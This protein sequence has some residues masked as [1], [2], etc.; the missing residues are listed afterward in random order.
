VP[1]LDTQSFLQLA[2]YPALLLSECQ[3][4]AK[5]L[6]FNAAAAQLFQDLHRHG[7]CPSLLSELFSLDQLA[8]PRT[9]SAQERPLRRCFDIDLT[10][11][12]EGVL[13]LLRDVTESWVQSRLLN[14]LGALQS[15]FL[16]GGL[17]REAFSD[18]LSL[19]LEVT[20]SEYG[21]VGEVLRD[22]N[23][24]PY[25]RTFAI[26]DVTWDDATRQFFDRHHKNGLEFRN[27]NTLFGY[28]LINGQSLIANSPADHPASVGTPQG[29]PPLNS[30]LALPL[31]LG[32]EMVGL[33]GIANRP[34]GYENSILDWLEP[35]SRVSAGAIRGFQTLQA[36]RNLE[37]ERDAYLNSSSAIH[38]VFDL[39]GRFHRVNPALCQLL[40]L[41]PE[42]IYRSDFVAFVHPDDIEA[43]RSEFAA[44]V[45]GRAANGFEN[46]F[47]A[48]DGSYRWLRWMTPPPS[49]D[50]KFI[51]ATAMDITEHKRM[52]DEVHRL[53]LV[54]QRTNN[55]IIL[56][57]ASGAIE[58][59][60][61]GF[62]RLSGYTLDEVRGLKPGSFLQGPGTDPA[63][64][65]RIR[66]AIQQKQGFH[67]QILNYSKDGSKY[68]I[69]LEV[70]PLFDR[71]GQLT[72]YMAV[73]LDITARKEYEQRLL[74]NERLLQTAGAMAHLGGWEVDLN[75][76]SLYWSDEVCRIHEVPLG[77]KPT[78][79]ECINYFAPPARE[80]VSRLV[81]HSIATG[82]PWDVELPLIT[83][84]GREVWVRTVS[85]PQFENGQC[86]RLV[87]C[88]QEIT[89]R[90]NQE[91]LIRRS[92]ARHRA[93]LAA[94]PDYIVQVDKDGIVVDFHNSELGH[95]DFPL[96]HAV[97]QPLRN[98]IS[99]DLWVRFARAFEQI[100]LDGHVEIID[101]ELPL[102]GRNYV[103][104][105]RLSRTQLG[106][107][108]V[109]I[110]D[111]TTQRESEIQIQDYVES[112]ESTRLELDFARR[113]AE[114]ANRSK[115]QF[116][117]VM[118]H[119]IRTP[120]NAI[121][122]MSR[123]LLDT[124]MSPEQREMSGT[125]MRSGEA[126]LEIINDILD[127]SKIE[128][129]R[130]DL[131]QIDFDLEQTLE[132]VI[133]LMLPKAREKGID[134]AFWFD[135][136][137]PRTV[138]GDPG[139]L[140]Q[141]ALNFVSNA[142]KFTT[143]GYVLLRVESVAQGRIRV[144]VEDTGIGIASDKVCRL[145]ERFSQ[146]DSSTT[147]KFGGTGLGLAIVREL[148]E[149]MQGAV[150]VRSIPGEGSTFWFEIELSGA[151]PSFV[152]PPEIPHI[153]LEENS[154]ALRA[155]A[156]L[157]TE[158]ARRYPPNTSRILRVGS[159]PLPHLL[160]GRFF[161]ELI[162]G[163]HGSP[164]PSGE[165][166]PPL[167]DFSGY[168]VLLVEDNLIN[169]KVGFRLLEKLKCTVDLAANGFEAVQMTGQLPYDLVFMDCQMPE[170]DGFQAARQIRSLGGALK[171]VPIV[172][173]TAAATPEDRDR[174]LQ[175]GMNDYLTKPVGVDSLALALERWA[176]PLRQTTH[177]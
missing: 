79:Q 175:S 73:E 82:E 114:E 47:R 98:F 84:K 50:A 166:K 102:T 45:A 63:T 154:T 155:L 22:K 69:E 85:K 81:Q 24:A 121:I 163:N 72:H 60:N 13:A 122:G 7:P 83:A 158:F 107:F 116:L 103:F 90:R 150:G 19:V 138:T 92:E 123:L 131:E 68:W 140:R 144:E 119:E 165:P 147:R 156:R 115:S 56:T 16:T 137:S 20:A 8:L 117:A 3:T 25:L 66:Q 151:P 46:R 172:A 146:A 134:L 51:Y 109:L 43:S 28:V 33:L 35:F 48:A 55:L 97:G 177:S 149:L 49:S 91:E 21:F 62:S 18:L 41:A 23:D 125:V 167:P 104:E 148:A 38:I 54:A 95:S 160:S 44:V 143:R 36:Q 162:G 94:V 59:V 11:T 99:G 130:V 27:L 4:G 1:A 39:K 159:T 61:E 74:D 12:P 113:R 127:F 118:S 52:A 129:G 161:A 88:L 106:D 34:G 26:T 75:S 17:E 170:M 78:M 2:P 87:G 71:H 135:P 108:L 168:R 174:C 57:D 10:Q 133:E 139:R 112:L 9:I 176:A 14:G 164:Q 70:Q 110:R 157:H 53:A 120:M 65:A 31:K 126:L 76:G 173:L 40:G 128:A 153:H 132:D 145:F 142:I 37:T 101:Y 136:L 64:V 86:R 171:R 5:V 105:A 111:I 152:L 141:M 6:D 96:R 67:E 124:P 93:L 77:Y 89:E 42:E 15:K 169:Q 32:N 80:I 30:F 58:W 100:G 29:H